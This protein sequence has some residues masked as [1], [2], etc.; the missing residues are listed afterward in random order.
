MMLQMAGSNTLVQAMVPDHLRGRVMAV[1]SMMF[2]GMA[3]LG[4]LVAGS[5]ANRLG[6][7]GTVALGGLVCIVAG[8]VFIRRLPRFR[9]E[10]REMIVAMEM[11][12]GG[13]AEEV[14]ADTSLSSETRSQQAE[15][16]D[17]VP[18]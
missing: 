13:P 8:A 16:R 18:S 11:A 15:R 6:S 5:L 10:A 7:P 4:A 1:Y 2:M 9:N 3:P 14:T 12:G 17:S